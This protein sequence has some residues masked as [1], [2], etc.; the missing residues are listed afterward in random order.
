MVQ[1]PWRRMT[2]L[3]P[4]LFGAREAVREARGQQ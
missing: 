4:G 2:R 1:G 3:S